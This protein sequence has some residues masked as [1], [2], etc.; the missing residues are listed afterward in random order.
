ARARTVHSDDVIGEIKS[1]TFRFRH[2]PPH[3][4]RCHRAPGDRRAPTTPA[5]STDAARAVISESVLASP[6]RARL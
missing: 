5:T 4:E 3:R 2:P 1:L 6:R